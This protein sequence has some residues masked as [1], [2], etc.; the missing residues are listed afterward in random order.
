MNH[1]FNPV[2][3]RKY[4]IRGVYDKDFNATDGYYIGRCFAEIVKE[5]KGTT[6]VVGY[7]G[8]LSS[9]ALEKSI[10]QGLCDSG[11]D[12]IQIGLVPTPVLYFSIKSLK[13]AGGMMITGSHNAGHYNGVKMALYDRP[14][15]GKDIEAFPE[16]VPNF[17]ESPTKGSVEKFDAITPF[18]KKMATLAQFKNSAKIVW[19]ISN[20]AAGAVMPDL[21]TKLPGTHILLNEKIDGTFPNHDPDPTKLGNLGQLISSIKKNKADLGIAFDGDGDRICAVTNDG[22]QVL[23]DLL[24]IFFAHDILQENPGAPIIADIKASQ[25]FIDQIIKMGGKPM[26]LPTGH[27]NIKAAMK[28]YNCPLA[29]ELSGHIFFAENHGYDD[30]IYASIKLLNILAEKKYSFSEL[31]N[32]LP[33]TYTTPEIR[34]ECPESLKFGIIESIQKDVMKIKNVDVTTIDGVRV[35]T[36]HGWWLARASNTENCIII[37]AES[38]T[39]EGLKDLVHTLKEFLG[40]YNLSFEN[41]K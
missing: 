18:I 23:G 37:R 3:L 39:P 22:K 10:T 25:V 7:D 19:D 24:L 15:W 11:L 17:S 9:P 6:V 38:I 41:C 2:I 14:V 8:R 35:Q 29:G 27:S 31:V 20:G 1:N 34:I 12:V 36:D 5:N 40:R 28:E 32:A 26:L 13:A 33:K 30:A 21:I 4:D 16:M